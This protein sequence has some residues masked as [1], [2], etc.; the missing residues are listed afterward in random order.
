[1]KPHAINRAVR[2]L[3]CCAVLLIA[4]VGNRAGAGTITAYSLP[5]IYEASQTFSLAAGGTAVPV[6]AFSKQYDYAVCTLSGEGCELQINRLD[7]KPIRSQSISPEK[8][9]IAGS[10]EGS[11]LHFR[12]STPAY[13]IVSIDDLRKLVIAIDPA[14]TDVPDPSA[15]DTFNVTDNRYHADSSGNSSS[16]VAIRQAINDAAND[17]SKHGIVYVPNGVYRVSSLQL[18][19]DVSL[20]LESGAVL[21]CSGQRSDFAVRY[22]KDSRNRDGTWFIYTAQ[23]AKNIR[24]FGRGTID[25][26]GKEM[27]RRLQLINDL[28]VPLDCSNFT[29][30]GPVLRDSSLWGTIIANS[31]HVT[32][33]NCKHFNHLDI[34]EDDCLD[35]CNSSN[36]LIERSIAI[37]LD[38]SYSCKT[39]G[40]PTDMS[41]QWGAPLKPNQEIRFNGCLAWSRCFGFKIG[42]GVFQPQENITVENSTCYD[43]AHAIG[44]SATYGFADVRNITFDTIDVERTRCMNLGRSWARFAIDS[45]DPKSP[46]GGVYNLRVR[47]IR[48]RDPG[49]MPVPIEGLNNGRMF[50]GVT[51]AQILMPGSDAPA[52]TLAQIGIGETKFAD[53]ISISAN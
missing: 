2:F 17:P 13:L 12:I 7:G 3:P 28:V 41:R 25:G 33:R 27:D 50:H 43:A 51:F 30:D 40:G 37:S 36:V 16:T 38:D 5:T 26:D 19:S 14:E 1:M 20:Y 53:G 31:D 4:M 52:T 35:V 29:M 45:R 34:G 47:N 32:L 21:R 46:A 11:H 6:I 49:T 39:W 44:I 24:I 15:R 23:G 18:P 22:H 8:L 48:V 42:A 10:V 9:G